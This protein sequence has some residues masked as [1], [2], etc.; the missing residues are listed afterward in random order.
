MDAVVVSI[1]PPIQAEVSSLL[2]EADAVAAALYP[3]EDRRPITAKSLEKPGTYVLV[4]RCAGKAV[5]LCV[6]FHRADKTAELKRMIVDRNA[7]GM[8]IGK[9]LLQGAEAE[10]LRLGAQE[11]VLEVGI[12]N[13]EAQALYRRAGYQPCDAF[14]PYK[15]LPISL[16]MHR[17]I[18]QPSSA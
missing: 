10:A 2:R 14:P 8:G 13:T 4:A 9:A 12:R 3:G 17:L 18:A 11:I 5:G 7:R 15:A 6:L 16:F 1:E